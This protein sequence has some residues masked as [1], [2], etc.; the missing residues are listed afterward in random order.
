MEL[1]FQILCD[2]E[3]V[4]L[5][6]AVPSVSERDYEVW[7][8]IAINATKPA[9]TFVVAKKVYEESG[10]AIEDAAMV[11]FDFPDA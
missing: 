1:C 3:K 9:V 5:S 2:V 8:L 11:L 10:C 7:N 6:V 4:A